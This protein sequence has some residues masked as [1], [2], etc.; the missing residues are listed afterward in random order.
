LLG[1]ENTTTV[2][3]NARKTNKQTIHQH[4]SVASATIISVSYTNT[5]NVQIIVQNVQHNALVIG[6]V[7]VIIHFVQL[8]V[9]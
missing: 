4:V 9:Y 3:C 8:F 1:C 7:V 6:A 5:N 2:G